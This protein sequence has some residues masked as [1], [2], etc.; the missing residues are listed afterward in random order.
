MMWVYIWLAVACASAL[1]EAFT[2]QMVSIWFIAG[3]IVA[4]ILSACGV[5]VEIQIVAFI[6]VSLIA[7]LSLRSLCMKYLLRKDT[8][9][10]NVDAYQDKETKL[11]KAITK[12]E[13]GEIKLGGIVWTAVS[14]NDEAI[15]K[16]TLVKILRVEGNKM[17]VAP[18]QKETQKTKSDTQETKQ[19]TQKT[20]KQENKKES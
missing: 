14:E 15:E 8:I 10:T 11:L 13:S 2:M 1:I 19:N 20:K 17:I 3:G 4:L 16:D 5:A 7:M 18:A 6:A 12:D 9:K